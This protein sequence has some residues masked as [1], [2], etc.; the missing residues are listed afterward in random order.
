MYREAK[1]CKGGYKSCK[2]FAQNI[3]EHALLIMPLLLLLLISQLKLVTP[4]YIPILG[5]RPVPLL[6]R[7]F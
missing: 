6:L 4:I 2:S 1:K 3:L 7:L 5:G